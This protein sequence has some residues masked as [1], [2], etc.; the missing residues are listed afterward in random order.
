M[1]LTIIDGNERIISLPLPGLLAMNG[2]VIYCFFRNNKQPV[3]FRQAQLMAKGMRSVKKKCPGIPL[4]EV[5]A[6]DTLIRIEA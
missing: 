4:L 5:R 6:E 3:T 2:A 1:R